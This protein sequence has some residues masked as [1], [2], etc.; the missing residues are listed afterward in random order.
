MNECR[1]ACFL[2]HGVYVSACHS[3]TTIQD[4][5]VLA[6][7]IGNGIVGEMIYNATIVYTGWRKKNVSNF[8][9]ALCSRVIKINEVKSTYSVSKHLRISLNFFPKTLLY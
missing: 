3:S 9:I 6:Y 5:H 1:V 8:R 7:L 4:T 2:T